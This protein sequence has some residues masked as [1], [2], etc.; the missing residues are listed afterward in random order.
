MANNKV[1]MQ[2]IAD[3]CGLSRNTVSK[4][5]NGR[6]NVP[7]NTRNHILKKAEELGYKAIPSEKVFQQSSHGKVIALLSN[8]LP[9]EYHFGTYF[10]TT[11]TDRICRAGYNLKMFEISSEELKQKELPPHFF[12]DQTAGIVGIELF[13][14]DYLDYICKLGIPTIMLDSPTHASKKLMGCDFVAM[15][16]RAGIIEIVNYIISKGAGKIGF[17]GDSEHCGSFYDRWIGYRI[18]LMDAGI[19]YNEKYCILDPDASPYG[20]V[21]WI[22]ERVSGLEEIPDA[23]VCANDFLAVHLMKALKKLG[24]SIPG[25]VRVAGFDGTPQSAVVEPSLT[26]VQIPSVDIGRMSA[27]ILLGRI[28]NPST[29]Y[30]WTHV[31]CNPIFRKSTE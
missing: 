13:D 15:E 5:F 3:A 31:R 19:E 27:D 17:Y 1:T 16:S 18:A 25:D 28:S 10:V 7:S 11:F 9:A 6:G 22:A 14:Q 4:V 20:D 12:P 8:K 29:P 23:F 24:L 30:S 26:T 2:D 21:D